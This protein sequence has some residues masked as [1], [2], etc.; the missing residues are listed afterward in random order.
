[1]AADQHVHLRDGVRRRAAE[2][3]LVGVDQP[4]VPRVRAVDVHHRRARVDGGAPG[5]G[6]GLEVQPLRGPRVQRDV[7]AVPEV[8]PGRAVVGF[9]RHVIVRAPIRRGLRQRVRI[10]R[11]AAAAGQARIGRREDGPL[12]IIRRPHQRVVGDGVVPPPA[13]VVADLQRDARG[14]LLLQVDAPLPVDRPHAPA[15]QQGRV[16]PRRAAGLAEVE[17]IAGQRAARVP[18]RNGLA[19]RVEEVAIDDKVPVG[20][21]PAAARRYPRF[22]CSGC[23]RCRSYRWSQAPGSARD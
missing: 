3:R 14:E 4:A 20:V 10:D 16:H 7:D 11:V 19:R 17:G 18:A 21:R 22:A 5:R 9:E 1:M 23:W 2:R 12:L 15:G 13:P 6:A 8:G